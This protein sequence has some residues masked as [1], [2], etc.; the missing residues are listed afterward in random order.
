MSTA[1]PSRV[2]WRLATLLLFVATTEAVYAQTEVTYEVH[3]D[4]TVR[5][6]T[7]ADGL[8]VN[9][10]NDL[11]KASDGY[12]WISSRDG[13][14]R[15]GGGQFTV[16]NTINTPALSSNRIS[17]LH[18]SADGH[19]WIEVRPQRL[20]R[21]RAGQFEQVARPVTPMVHFHTTGD[22][23]WL[24]AANGLAMYRNGV[25]T[26]Y[27]PD[28]LTDPGQFLLR[29][30]SGQVWVNMPSRGI[31]RF[32]TD[33]A[34]QWI[35]Q[36]EAL[37]GESFDAAWEDWEEGIWVAG[38]H[39]YHLV[40][41]QV[42][43]YRDWSTGVLDNYRQHRTMSMPS[44]PTEAA[45]GQAVHAPGGAIWRYMIN[46]SASS[47]QS[48]EQW[49][50]VYRDAKQI[51][52]VYGSRIS[53]IELDSDGSLW[54]L[55]RSN[56]LFHLQRR[57]F[58]TLSEAAG[59]PADNVYPV[60]QARDGSVW[61]GTVNGIAVTDGDRV[62]TTFPATS[63]RGDGRPASV[64]SLLEEASG[65]VWASTWTGV[66]RIRGENCEPWSLPLEA[67]TGVVRAMYED[68]Q[69]RLWMG[70]ARGLALRSGG[71][72][73]YMWQWLGFE[74]GQTKQARVIRQMHDGTILIGTN[75]G[76]LYRYLE[77]GSFE[78]LQVHTAESMLPSNQIR[79]I[80]ED[81]EGFVWLALEDHGLCRLDW[82][83]QPTLAGA[84][85][86]CL[87][88]EDGL[89]DNSLHRILEDDDGRFWF[90]TNRGIFWVSRA[91]VDAYI[92]GGRPL[93]TSVAY[94]EVDG[95]RNQEGNGGVQPAGTRTADG[96]L[97]FPTVG[98]VVVV[99]P[100]RV[101]VPSPQAVIE[102]V[103]VEDAARPTGDALVLAAEE[104]D[105]SFALLGVE[106]NQ[107]EDVHVQY[108]VVGYDDTWHAAGS[109]WVASYTN[110]EPGGYR[111]EVRAGLGGVWSAPVVQELQRTAL[112]WETAWFFALCGVLLMGLVYGGFR[113]R[114][115][116]LEAR[117]RQLEATVAARTS[118]IAARTS[119]VEAQKAQL[120]EQ[121]LELKKAND[122]KS[123]FLANIAHEFRTPLT[124]TFGPI[125]DLLD[126]RFAV[127]DKAKPHLVRAQ[128]NGHRLLRLINQLLDLSRIDAGNHDLQLTTL[129][130]ARHVREI[131]SL[132]AEV[133]M[134]RGRTFTTDF[135][136]APV[137]VTADVDAIE[138]IVSNL[139]SNALK[140]T[141]PADTVHASVT[142]DGDVARLVIEDTGIGIAVEHLPHLFDRFYQ[143]E[144]AKTRS[145]EGSGI[146]LAL[147]KE[148]VDLLGG[149]IEVESTVGVGTRFRISLPLV[150]APS[151]GDGASGDRVAALL[152][153]VDTNDVDATAAAPSLDVEPPDEVTDQPVVLIVEDNADMRAYVR[154]HLED[155]FLMY[156][157]INGAE[158]VALARDIV[159]D[160]IVSD[161][162]MPEMDGHALC[163][164]IKD[165]TTTSHVP[166][167]LLTARGRA[168]DRIDGYDAGADAYLAKPFYAKELRARVAGLIAE[169]RR[170]R[171]YYQ[172]PSVTATDESES[173]SS[174]PALP[175]Q[176]Q[177]FLE[178]IQALLVEHLDVPNFGM[179]QLA[180][181]MLMSRR[182]LSRKVTAL[183]GEAP[184]AWQRRLRM[185][186][187]RVL[188]LEGYT[189]KE[190][191]PR[192]GFKSTT[193]FSKA[194]SKAHGQ[195]P[196]SFADAAASQ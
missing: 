45:T 178:A 150:A 58:T 127:E 117:Q 100:A 108:R 179:D 122:V 24:P 96:W 132:F 44:T 17:L 105:V 67:N 21:Y 128:R 15:F 176:E 114:V 18:E 101:P 97:W 3:P 4:Y 121:A 2:W 137:W 175:K 87:T 27:R 103:R 40:G 152:P 7:T 76:G 149:E 41:G 193:S 49:G 65:Q 164:A 75:G 155:D 146:G 168:E 70:A 190:V 11:L 73:E 130:L 154:S 135:S 29:D 156:E 94:T 9:G 37:Q 161:V 106:P 148:L 119:E 184:G 20:V 113:Y 80:Y 48:A 35:D 140:F 147:V 145:H 125:A 34:V 46:L 78:I 131:A 86:A 169:R 95:M 187:A 182:Q 74:G 192:V 90:N 36:D 126:G 136:A 6:W 120:A 185:D 144:Q 85:L 54:V 25:E 28:I 42:R 107:P 166:V 77:K 102:S 177:V 92:A 158:G 19:L 196:R 172:G 88:T 139:L 68:D 165:E 181:E 188:L 56:G 109:Q 115:R 143:V 104:R 81:A 180:S 47:G 138:H 162:M 55:T 1:R 91:E 69:G 72:G 10:G 31:A 79:D 134:Q 8:P 57:L 129:D 89:Y 14:T 118:E 33:G 23:L 124:L 38:T 52:E 59:L 30:R 82:E 22:T 173:A 111:F 63:F 26:L 157:A 171:T 5:H 160:L 151:L 167:L 93:L 53:S 84:D 194:F 133:T 50:R 12:L 64:L 71:P 32:S 159:P 153:L 142:Q 195:A 191:A 61:I 189:V 62:E 51:F 186:R 183:T 112:F 99:D 110:L 16:F 170:L 60:M 13:L 116:Q 43:Y 83:G 163:R 141:E 174:A 66:C 98:G 39:T 123:H